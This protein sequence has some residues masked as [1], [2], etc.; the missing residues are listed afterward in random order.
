MLLAGV[1]L[2][3]EMAIHIH[4]ESIRLFDHPINLLGTHLV[5]CRVGESR[6]GFDAIFVHHKHDSQWNKVHSR[7]VKAKVGNLID[8]LCQ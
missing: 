2:L 3:M 8:G 6:P 4:V 5:S 1:C 7:D